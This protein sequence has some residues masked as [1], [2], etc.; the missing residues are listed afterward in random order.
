MTKLIWVEA[1]SLMATTTSSL[2]RNEKCLKSS[3]T[4]GK[5]TRASGVY[6]NGT[7]PLRQHIQIRN[8]PRR[9]EEQIVFRETNSIQRYNKLNFNSIQIL[10][11]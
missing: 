9:A 7:I 11:L 6:K 3:I 1:T 8:S 10:F 5:L 2:F 4:H